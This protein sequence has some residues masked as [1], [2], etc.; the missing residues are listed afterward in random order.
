MDPVVGLCLQPPRHQRSPAVTA[1]PHPHEQN[2]SRPHHGFV[3]EHFAGAGNVGA[4]LLQ[5]QPAFGRYVFRSNEE[6]SSIAWLVKELPFCAVKCV[7]RPQPEQITQPHRV[8]VFR[9]ATSLRFRPPIL[10][11][12]QNNLL[13]AMLHA[14]PVRKSQRL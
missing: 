9:A 12:S 5:S 11:V 13:P 8:T 1:C 3:A 14:L 6:H 2:L 10:N 4:V 7:A